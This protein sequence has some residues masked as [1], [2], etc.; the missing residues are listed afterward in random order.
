MTKRQKSDAFK[1]LIIV[2]I[3]NLFAERFVGAR[4]IDLPSYFL[5]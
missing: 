3:P 4:A 5:L 1:F 2:G